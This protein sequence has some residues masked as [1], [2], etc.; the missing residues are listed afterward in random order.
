MTHTARNIYELGMDKYVPKDPFC[1]ML[2]TDSPLFYPDYMTLPIFQEAQYFDPESKYIR[3]VVDDHHITLKYGILPSVER[4][5]IETI[6]S[7]WS[8]HNPVSPRFGIFGNCF[9][10]FGP[11]NADYE[12]VVVPVEINSFIMGIH[13]ELNRLPNVC[14]FDFEPHITL[15]YFKKGFW[16]TVPHELCPP[17]K[18]QIGTT[19]FVVTGGTN[20]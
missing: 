19:S 7:L 17:L 18:S 4:E 20:A 2:G 12:A 1:V 10:V 6:L 9:Q 15:G 13:Y 8:P 11:K 14:T 5:D 16:E 3:G